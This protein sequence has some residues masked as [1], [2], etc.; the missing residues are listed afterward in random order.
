MVS[1]N[2]GLKT[3]LEAMKHGNSTD[4]HLV[5]RGRKFWRKKRPQN[6]SLVILCHT[7]TKGIIRRNWE[8]MTHP[9]F[10]LIREGN[11]GHFVK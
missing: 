7:I 6:K 2:S 11:L 4:Q 3:Q 9:L 10:P 1:H 8:V 5:F